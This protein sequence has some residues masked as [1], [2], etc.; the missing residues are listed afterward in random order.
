MTRAKGARLVDLLRIPWPL[1][2]DAVRACK[3]MDQ[4]GFRCPFVGNGGSCALPF[5]ST[6]ALKTHVRKHYRE[7]ECSTCGHAFADAA[8][9]LAHFGARATTEGRALDA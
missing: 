2:A 9:F 6:K 8:D 7:G 4:D 1:H 5:A 3:G